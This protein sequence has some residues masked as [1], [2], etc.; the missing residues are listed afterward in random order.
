MQTQPRREVLRLAV[1]VEAGA[2]GL[3]LLL[4]WL[5][6]QPPLATFRWD[7][8]AAGWGLLAATP[9]LLLFL[10]CFYLP[11]GPLRRIKRLAAQVIRP[12]FAPCTLF[13]LALISLLAGLGEEML[14]RGVLQ[15]ALT[16]WLGPWPGIIG[17]GVV[18]GVLHLLT[19]AYGLLATLMGI[20]LGGAWLAADNLLTP[21]TAHAVY[22]FIALVWLVRTKM[23]PET[24]A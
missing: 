8:G 13:D 18:F 16:D 5:L 6:D 9:L 20:Y 19:P 12:L 17:A 2:G 1:V 10:L 14:F 4:G 7:V 3:A 21:V 11:L 15:A 22:D 24:E 23:A